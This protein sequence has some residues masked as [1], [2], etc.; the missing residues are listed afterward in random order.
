MSFYILIWA[1][2]EFVEYQ[3]SEI[4]TRFNLQINTNFAKLYENFLIRRILPIIETSLILGIIS[5][6]KP[7]RRTWNDFSLGQE[8]FLIQEKV[9][10]FQWLKT[11]ENGHKK[12]QCDSNWSEFDRKS[13]GQLWLWSEFQHFLY[14]YSSFCNIEYFFYIKLINIGSFD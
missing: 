14:R 13:W 1:F 3:F 6:K 9:F 8:D 2:L 11:N 12:F 10:I 7:A 5:Y 4:N